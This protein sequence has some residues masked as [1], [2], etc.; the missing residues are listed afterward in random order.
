V[1]VNQENRV[2]EQLTR[3]L[4]LG[5]TAALSDGQLL[6]RFATDRGER[7][8]QA[9]AALVERH[10]PMVLRVCRSVLADAHL[11]EDAFQATFLVL[12]RKGRRLWV[13]ESLGPWLHQ[14]ALRTA[15]CARAAAARRRRHERAAVRDT[16]ATASHE[17]DSDLERLL[18][19]EIGR[20]PER[21][22]VPLILCEL[23]GLT[24]EH[25]AR[26]LGWP[27]GTV[28]SRL[29]RARQRLRERLLRRGFAPGVVAVGTLR[30][31]TP[32]FQVPAEVV[33]ST[34]RAAAHFAASRAVLDGP[35]A[36]L[37]HGVLSAMNATRWWKVASLLVV[38]GVTASGAGLIAAGRTRAVEP[39][40]QEA[41]SDLPGDAGPIAVATAMGGRFEVLV[42]ERGQLE[43]T[44]RESIFCNV[45]GRTTII[46]LVPEGTRVKKGDLV[47]ELD[48][49]AIR[50]QLTNQRATAH[51]AEAAAQNARLAREV[52]EIAVTEFEEG[53]FPLELAAIQGEI[54]LA[55]S[56]FL[57]AEA[58]VQRTRRARERMN[59]AITKKL[60]KSEPA[61]VLADL[62]VDDRLATAER[63][64]LRGRLVLEQAQSRLNLIQ[65]YTK[66]KRI[67]ELKGELEK[68]LVEEQARKDRSSLERSRITHL[69]KQITNCKLIAPC[70]GTVVYGNNSWRRQGPP[71]IEEGAMVRERQ[72]LVNII[73]L[74]APMQVN[75]KVPEARI[76]QVKP[77]QKVRVA[78]DAFPSETF[79]GLVDEVAP[80]PDPTAPTSPVRVFTT[81]VR[82]VQKSPQLRPN[83]TATADII[84]EERDDV[85]TVPSQAV[86]RS[87]G[88]WQ[89]AVKAP[90]GGFELRDVVPGE[91]RNTVVEIKQGLKPGEQVALDLPALFRRGLNPHTPKKAP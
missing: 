31:L 62:D 1:D 77:G 82:L 65:N 41:G 43:P 18:H 46:M 21:Y 78:I 5:T 79:T 8:E 61:D 33:S 10:G 48:T 37:A 53:S 35:A 88:K 66:G 40:P 36:L 67:K 44:H 45:E 47:G 20:L 12:A 57:K 68:A 11:A 72:I 3:L 24:Q 23:E 9:F 71:A 14:V 38:A 2:G 55:E 90:G 76:K 6:E 58:R 85:L 84:V 27:I 75:V 32:D 73:D 7:A 13:E 63:E 60:P 30:P 29:A 42:T 69:E 87:P 56:D 17:P 25:A 81:K 91:V 16:A 34:A 15:S 52:T 74:G 59:D 83:M 4:T 70:D 51:A 80:L 28:K 54:K 39:R 49:A 89:V 50:D 86:I 26:T 64:L 22:R 19:E